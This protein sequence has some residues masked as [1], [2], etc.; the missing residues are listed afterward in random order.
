[1]NAQWEISWRMRIRVIVQDWDTKATGSVRYATL[2]ELADR[3]HTEVLTPC[4]DSV[5]AEAR[6]YVLEELFKQ[7]WDRK[8]LQEVLDSED[9]VGVHLARLCQKICRDLG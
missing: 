2:R 5:R 6:E 8:W 1:M 3:L 7:S 4:Y 9:S